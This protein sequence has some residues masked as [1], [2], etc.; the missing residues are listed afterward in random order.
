MLLVAFAGVALS[1]LYILGLH[2]FRHASISQLLEVQTIIELPVLP[3]LMLVVPQISGFSLRQ[4]G[5]SLPSLKN[6][7]LAVAGAIVMIV[8]VQ[9][10]ANIIEHL[11]RAHHEQDVTKLLKRLHGGS[12]YLLFVLTAVFVAPLVEEF[13]FRVFIFN[14]VLRR[15]PFLVAAIISGVLFGIAHLDLYVAGPLAVGGVILATVYYRTRN[16][17]CSMITHAVFNGATVVATFVAKD[18]VK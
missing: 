3:Y 10:S 17:W 18:L 15:A 16:A 4:L 9:G 7:G 13:T 6:V 2:D 11:S 1:A 8:V 5:F 12:Q 14:A